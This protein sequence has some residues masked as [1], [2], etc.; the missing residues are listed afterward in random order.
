[1]ESY[2]YAELLSFYVLKVF[3]FNVYCLL[4]NPFSFG[5]AF[6]PFSRESGYSEVELYV[7][8]NFLFRIMN[9]V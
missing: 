9:M 8:I 5:Q 7:R 6:W 4:H 3:E 1:M 2:I